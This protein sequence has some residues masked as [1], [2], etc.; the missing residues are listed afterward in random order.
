MR[1]LRNFIAGCW[2]DGGMRA[3][4]LLDP[5]IGR[6]G[7][8]VNSGFVGTSTTCSKRNNPNLDNVSRQ[9]VLLKDWATAVAKTSI[10]SASRDSSAEHSILNPSSVHGWRVASVGINHSHID[11]LQN[12]WKFSIDFCRSTQTQR[13]HRR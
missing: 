4:L 11:F 1:L 3:N 10:F 6:T 13:C 9:K 2:F 5:V 8:V 7:P 12:R